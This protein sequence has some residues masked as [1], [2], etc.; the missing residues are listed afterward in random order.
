MRWATKVLHLVRL[1]ILGRGIDGSDWP[2]W[3]GQ[4]RMTELTF[5]HAGWDPSDFVGFRCYA[6]FPI[7]RSAYHLCFDFSEAKRGWTKE[8]TQRTAEE[9]STA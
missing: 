1:E 3:E 4:R 6:E 2:G 9:P 8:R 7:W 5:E